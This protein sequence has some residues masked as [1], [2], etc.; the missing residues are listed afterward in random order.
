MVLRASDFDPLNNE[1]PFAPPIDP[2]T[3]P[4]KTTGTA[5]QITE[6]FCREKK[7]KKNSPPTAHFTL[8]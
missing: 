6:F 8:F 2:V 5:A 7:T 3:A 4:I 1:N